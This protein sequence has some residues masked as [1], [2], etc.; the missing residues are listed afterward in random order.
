ML[1]LH[2]AEG[3]VDDAVNV[4]AESQMIAGV[5]K[6]QNIAPAL[7]GLS[8]QRLT[9]FA[10]DEFNDHSPALVPIPVFVP[11]APVFTLL[12]RPQAPVF[13]V[14]MLATLFHQPMTVCP[15]FPFVPFVIVAMIGIIITVY[16][17][18]LL[19]FWCS[20]SRNR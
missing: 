17:D 6:R 5:R 8:M 14:S 18:L 2:I 1:R 19:R 3:A 20:H 11:P 13:P 9:A 10:K 7:K 15:R 4:F 12:F 16:Y